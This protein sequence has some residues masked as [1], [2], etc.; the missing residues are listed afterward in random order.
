[1]SQPL[2]CLPC[3]SAWQAS[4]YCSLDFAHAP[5]LP[6]C[7]YSEITLTCESDFLKIEEQGNLYLN[8]LG[9]IL[10]LY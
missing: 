7:I 6:P 4:P 9:S 3:D 10:F 2:K 1:M 5:G 8:I